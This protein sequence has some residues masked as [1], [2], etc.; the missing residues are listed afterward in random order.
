MAVVGDDGAGALAAGSSNR[1]GK[2]MRVFIQFLVLSLAVA[3]GAC[4]YRVEADVGRIQVGMT[5]AQVMSALGLPAAVQQAGAAKV[6]VYKNYSR[7]L[8]DLSDQ[9]LGRWNRDEVYVRIV[10]GAVEGY[11]ADPSLVRV[12]SNLVADAKAWC[13][14]RMND[15]GL[16]AMSGKLPLASYE[17]ISATMLSIE[18]VP[19]SREVS[20]IKSLA[21][22]QA[23][24][25]AK[26]VT[27]MRTEEP[28]RVPGYEQFMFKTDLV[29]AQ[30]MN[31]KISFGNANR[32]LKEAYL[33]GLNRLTED[34]KREIAEAQDQEY[35]RRQLQVQ[36][37]IAESEAE[38]ARAAT[39]QAM[40]RPTPVTVPTIPPMSIPKTQQTS[41]MWIG[42]SLNCTTRLQ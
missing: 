42:S 13:S 32:L 6:L 9:S 21:D 37:S 10:G 25:R 35:K 17:E 20:A 39:I 31:R 22:A 7:W 15:A 12:S 29:Y 23:Q 40:P 38:K 16:Q 4:S 34:T 26:L 28:T 11:G 41:C 24:C 19:T 2:K 3:V 33:D 27:A 8:T 36:E 18:A 1:G 14:Q 30:L 5:E